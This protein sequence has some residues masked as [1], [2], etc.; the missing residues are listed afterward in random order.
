MFFVPSI[1][2]DRRPSDLPAS[3]GLLAALKRLKIRRLGDLNNTVRG[4][5]RAVS[6][7]HLLTELD[8]IIEHCRA[9]TATPPTDATTPRIN[10]NALRDHPDEPSPKAPT[11]LD[12][13]TSQSVSNPRQDHIFIPIDL[14]GTPLPSPPT[15]SVRLSN[16][17]TYKKF[18]IFGDLHGLPLSDFRRFRNCGKKTVLELEGLVRTVQGGVTSAD[19]LQQQ[20]L[21]EP[22]WDPNLLSVASAARELD[23]YG[24]PLSVRA[25]NIL[26]NLGVKHLADLE[27]ITVS[28]LLELENCG[29]QTVR[30]IQDLLRRAKA[31][32]FDIAPDALQKLHPLDLLS[33]ID[34]ML[35]RLRT[36]DLELITLRLG[37]N[38]QP[39]A[40]LGIIGTQFNISR[41]RVRQIVSKTLRQ[42]PR[43]G[44]PKT[45]AL[46]DRI[47]STCLKSVFPLT[48]A[49][50]L[51]WAP[52]PW[53]MRYRPEFYVR[54]IAE[55]CPNVPTWPEGQKYATNLDERSQAVSRALESFLQAKPRPLSLAEA[56]QAVRAAPKLRKIST[57]EFLDALRQTKYLRVQFPQPDRPEVSLK[58]LRLRDVART[59]LEASEQPLTPEDILAKAQAQFGAEFVPWTPIYAGNRL[60]PENGFYLLGPRSYGLRRHFSLPQSSW[61]SIR[62]DCLRALK[63][64]NHPVSSSEIVSGALFPWAPG[65]NSYELAQVLREDNRF[66]DLG[67]FLFALTA[68]G[69]EERDYIKDLIPKVLA[70][71]ARPAT[72][73]EVYEKLKRLRS[74]SP[75]SMSQQ[76][77]GTPRV[78]DYG[79]GHFGLKA[80]G[81]RARAQLASSTPFVEQVVRRAD[82]PL[83]FARLVEILGVPLESKT[84]QMLW[85][86]IANSKEIIQVPGT[87][88][89]ETVLVHKDCSIE[90]A[91]AGIASEQNRPMPSYELQ[92]HLNDCFG[93]MFAERPLSE[94]TKCIEQSRLFVRMTDGGFI[95]DTHLEQ[96][97]LD[98]D[99]IRTACGNLLSHSNEIIA[100]EDLI[101]R[102]QVD[103]KSWEDLSPAVLSSFLRSDDQF[104][105]IGRN[106]FRI[107]P[108]KR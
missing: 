5:V 78:Q 16:I 68:W 14:R 32:E 53:P 82:P 4:V 79:F 11:Q 107:R 48:P 71:I 54:A 37:G 43:R 49:L 12:L 85:P 13:P 55:M 63:R 92:W 72:A 74:L 96:L 18:R 66:I 25:E 101:D 10:G 104:E 23:P 21:L 98:E 105:E 67:K 9:T 89:P 103:G 50:L 51:K 56:L 90:R 57:H 41:E 83:R 30:E 1:I 36:R 29:T 19:L 8:G 65:T 46:L 76:I 59:I 24:L 17:L 42:L 33:Q 61:R 27:G 86:S 3:K 99:A 60:T 77:R 35:L 69:V 2:A 75:S 52:N 100:C 6:G 31:G 93:P 81:E 84:A 95:L 22:P 39:P 87:Q 108:C 97:G 26:K 28:Q 70:E 94:I 102:L 38:G 7:V 15:V 20:A 45:R 64:E 58:S 80:W 62:Q 91:L 106:R 40:V 44:G 73:A 47:A 34:E 88:G